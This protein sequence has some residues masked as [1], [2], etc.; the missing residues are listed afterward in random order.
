MRA[1][2]GG[3]GSLPASASRSRPAFTL[4]EMT[5]V[6][7]IIVLLAGLTMAVSV[8]VVKG[9]E[10][11]QTKLTIQLLETALREWEAQA[12]R[13]VTYG[14]PNEPTHLGNPYVYEIPQPDLSDPDDGE[15]VTQR[16]FAILMRSQSIREILA[17][18]DPEFTLLG[19]DGQPPT[20]FPDDDQGTVAVETMIVADAWGTPLAAVLPGRLWVADDPAVFGYRAQPDDDGTIRTEIE[21]VCGVAVNRRI[22]FVAAGPDGDLGNLDPASAEYNPDAAADNV[23]SYVPIPPDSP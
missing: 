6:I 1:A 12:D 21:L 11:R 15:I 5:I 14:K 22:C 23:Y 3:T 9:S 7:G 18:I 8:S 20:V 16:L 13:Q 19:D 10:I 17:R 4:V 2:Q